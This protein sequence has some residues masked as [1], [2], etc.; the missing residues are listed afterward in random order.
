MLRRRYVSGLDHEPVMLGSSQCMKSLGECIESVARHNCTVLIRGESGSGKELC[1]RRIHAM[2][3]R[4]EGPFVPVDCTT[5]TGTLFESQLFGHVRGAFTGAQHSALGFFRSAE[6]GTLFLDEIGELPLNVQAKLLR[7]LQEHEVVPLG[8]TT[9]I[10][11]NVRVVAATHRDLRQ[12]VSR[13]EFREDLYFRLNVACIEVPP[14]RGRPDD[15]PEIARAVLTQ[16]CSLYARP[17]LQTS[18]AAMSRLCS[19]SWPGNVR[20]LVNA[21]EHALVFARGER[22]EVHDLPVTIAG[23]IEGTSRLD[24]QTTTV[25]PGTLIEME[26]E[27]IRRTLDATN[28]NQSRAAAILGI[29]RHRLKRR[30]ALH[31][32]EHLVKR[33]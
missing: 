26:V 8:Q 30:I 22:I 19:Y 32:L 7:C 20:E 2:S 23:G 17:E 14:L 29:E 9:P 27:M 24:S 16:L 13:G 6:G 1:A 3:P 25:R 15:V 18:E 4:R 28:G 33:K 31:G 21:I 11:V 12:M 5:L 10:R